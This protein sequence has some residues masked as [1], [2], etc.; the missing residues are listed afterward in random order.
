M[1]SDPK[2]PHYQIANFEVQ[3]PFILNLMT[4][5]NANSEQKL[6]KL[7]Q[8]V[9]NLYSIFNNSCRIVGN[10]NTAFS[11]SRN[12]Y[13]ISQLC[14]PKVV[15]SRCPQISTAESSTINRDHSRRIMVPNYH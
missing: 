11:H 3:S 5:Q 12:G 13:R 15:R 14:R 1:V 4:E 7:Y 10:L 9:P 2:G 6:Q 8:K